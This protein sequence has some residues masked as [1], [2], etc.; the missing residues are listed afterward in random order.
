MACDLRLVCDRDRGTGP[1]GGSAGLGRQEL[2]FGVVSGGRTPGARPSLSVGGHFS[3][4]LQAS[5]PFPIVHVLK[6]GGSAERGSHCAHGEEEG[7]G[8]G[9]AR[10]MFDSQKVGGYS[11]L[12][13]PPSGGL[14]WASWRQSEQGEER[15]M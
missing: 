1:S 3:P 11:P 6:S 9:T 10:K 2:A 15:C 7:S 13:F 14:C 5:Q 8:R 4:R 12:D